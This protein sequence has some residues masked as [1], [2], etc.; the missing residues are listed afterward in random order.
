MR[1]VYLRTNA[2]APDPRVEKEVNSLLPISDLD[3]KVI[4]WDRS[5]KYEQREEKLI[6]KNG[7][8]PIIR[9]GIPASWGG[10]MKKNLKSVIL[11]EIK[12]FL[13]LIKNR[14]N[15]DCIHACDLMTGLPAYLPAKLFR[16][17]LVYDIFDYYSETQH[18]PQKILNIFKKMED[19][20]ISNSDVTIICSEKRKEQIKDSNPKQLE[21]IHNSP[22]I[23]GF[24]QIINKQK[25]V[26][27]II[28]IGNLVEDRCIRML[29]D[30]ISKRN[31]IKLTIGGFGEL[32]S[33]VK[34]YAETFSNIDFIGKKNYEEVLALESYSDI[35]VA[36][37][38]PKVPNHKFAAPN[39]FYEALA[40][41]K[42][43]IM[44]RDTG[45]DEIVEKN[46]IGIT[47]E[48]NFNSLNE[49]IDKMIKIKDEWTNIGIKMKEIYSQHY[50]WEKMEKRL[51]KIYVDLMEKEY[52]R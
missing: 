3:I 33:V 30:V 43:L 8:V 35:I 2:V 25:D 5:N 51:Q 39:K 42:P 4:A 19:Y 44:F 47:C 10:G 24:N 32:E 22:D 31:D 20:I 16:K 21:I 15:Y 27:N 9:F 26:P 36:L 29:M 38:D 18:G 11:F 28:Y 1:L 13:W 52:E 6:L 48:C 37:Y 23:R 34:K 46:S 45:V 49:G 50:S 17:K 12:L 41:G 7:Y 14:K 40:L